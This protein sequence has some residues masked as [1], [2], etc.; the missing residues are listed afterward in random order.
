MLVMADNMMDEQADTLHAFICKLNLTNATIYPTFVAITKELF[1]DEGKRTV[2][3]GRI[4]ALY[5]FSG[6]LARHCYDNGE[7]HSIE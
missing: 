4:V 2:K 1:E 5:A 3:W 6:A 7:S